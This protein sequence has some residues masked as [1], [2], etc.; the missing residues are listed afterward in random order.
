MHAFSPALCC[1]RLRFCQQGQKRGQVTGNHANQCEGCKY[2][3]YSLHSI[4]L[5]L[6]YRLIRFA[7]SL[8]IDNLGDWSDFPKTNECRLVAEPQGLNMSLSIN[9]QAMEAFSIL[10][11]ILLTGSSY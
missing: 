11:G 3:L 4:H 1:L 7:H 8:Q 9:M 10:W 2:C 6:C 5:L